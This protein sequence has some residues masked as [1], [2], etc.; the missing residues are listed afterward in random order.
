[1]KSI[2]VFPL[3]PF[4][5]ARGIAAGPQSTESAEIKTMFVDIIRTADSEHEIYFLLTSYIEAVR[6]SNRFSA[7]LEHLTR[8]PLHGVNDVNERF[9]KL[10]EEL[11]E[12]SKRLDD[13]GCVLIRE[14][15]H[16]I[17]TAL[18]RL[19]S[20]GKENAASE[21][22][23]TAPALPAT[24]ISAQAPDG[25]REPIDVLLV[26]DNP[27]DVRMTRRAFEAAGVPYH[28]HVVKDGDD[29]VSYLCQTGHFDHAPKPDVVLVD[30]SVP[31]LDAREVLS[32]IKR[33]EA[34]KHIPIVVLTCAL[35]ERGLQGRRKLHADHFVIKPLGVQAFAS[36]MKKI[37]VLAAR[38]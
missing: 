4:A 29:A 11:D 26:E 34:L 16:I 6:F 28:L 9:E 23:V 8:F 3:A 5:R 13:H 21:A 14:A 22:A 20:I 1:M 24:E 31:Q 18:N 32:E 2:S 35:A 10:V 25:P 19:Q 27:Y 33:S 30:L 38:H 37:D 36:E 12:A 17:G 15:L 7:T